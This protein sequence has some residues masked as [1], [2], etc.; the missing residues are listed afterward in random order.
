MSTNS[1]E[2]EPKLSAQIKRRR[3]PS[4][5][6]TDSLNSSRNLNEEEEEINEIHF[7]KRGLIIGEKVIDKEKITSGTV[8]S[9]NKHIRLAYEII[10]YSN[11][12]CIA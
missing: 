2:S 4:I 6:K 12:H 7:E 8:S 1:K 3:I 9:S 5:K 10:N 11:S